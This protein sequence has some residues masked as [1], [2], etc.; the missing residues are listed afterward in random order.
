MPPI[1][2]IGRLGRVYVAK[3]S[4]F[5]T[6]PT[7]ASSDALRHTNCQINIS[8][9]RVGSPERFLDPSLRS[10]FTRRKTGTFTLGG[11]LYPSGTLN[12]LPDT[13]EIFECGLGSKRNV[14]LS[15]TIASGPTTTGAT[16][17]S[18]AGL[19]VGDP[20]LINVTTGTP[21]TGRVLRWLLTV[22]GAVVTW[23]PPLPQAPATSDTVKGCIGYN[24]ATALP[25]ALEI[26]HYFTS[27]SK[28]ADGA[29]IDQLKLTLDANDEVKWN[30]SGPIADRLTTAQSIPGSFTTVGTQAPPS[31]LV[32]YMRMGASAVDF[33]KVEITIDNAQEMDN[34]AF[35]TSTAQNYFRKNQR[36]VMAAVTAILSDSTTLMAAA[37]NAT[38]S[39][40]TAWQCGQTE[41]NIVG[42][43]GPNLD[44]DVPDMPDG[45]E[46]L[47]ITFNATMKATSAGNDELRVAI[48]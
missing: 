42:L 8:N 31:G 28:E 9:N 17:T 23:D 33:L 26:G 18:A 27:I 25:N 47:E 14:T 1:Y 29:V 39:N 35:G 46:M 4:A 20:I 13:D 40:A 15:T 41:G 32:G 11:L 38:D 3:Q 22:A 30:A 43:Y 37:E 21:A 5:R 6:K 10:K 2:Q 44:F 34:F 19:A 48:A 7:F 45:E 12:T 24:L 36:K 16:L